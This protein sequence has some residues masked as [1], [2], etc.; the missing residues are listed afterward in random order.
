MINLT[1]KV[2]PTH[3]VGYFWNSR[4]TGKKTLECFNGSLSQCESF[5]EGIYEEWAAGNY[6]YDLYNE[7]PEPY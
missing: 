7:R 5:I 2:E 3:Y 1:K 6:T 4:L